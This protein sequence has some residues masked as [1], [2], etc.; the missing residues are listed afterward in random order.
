MLQD[1]TANDISDWFVY[2]LVEP[3]HETRADLR[4][5]IVA[6]AVVAVN[7]PKGKKRRKL[8]EFMPNYEKLVD[9]YLGSIGVKAP[10]PPRQI[11]AAKQ[12]IL[13]AAAKT[14]AK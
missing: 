2:S 7:T 1:M 10:K 4:T 11:A 5:A 3:F 12:I 6:Q 13:L 9:D 8:E 14:R